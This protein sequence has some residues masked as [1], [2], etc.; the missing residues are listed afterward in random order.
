LS[1]VK[2]VG[3]T[4]AE[5]ATFRLEPG[6]VLIVEGHANIDE[7]GRSAVWINSVDQVLH[8]NH[9]IRVRCRGGL[10]L[11]F[12]SAY[13]NGPRGRGYF[14]GMAKSTSGL[15][16]INSTVVKECRVPRVSM[17][18]QEQFVSRLELLERNQASAAV[19]AASGKL[20]LKSLINQIF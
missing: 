5:A 9:L 15:N 12:L 1:E 8:Q 4:E 16:T 3:V 20:L 17:C 18:N 10:H 19:S 11:R 6:D 2:E 13:I 14:K 7:I